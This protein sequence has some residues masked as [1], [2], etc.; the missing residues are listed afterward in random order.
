LFQLPTLSSLVPCL[1]G[2]QL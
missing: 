1:N 2:P